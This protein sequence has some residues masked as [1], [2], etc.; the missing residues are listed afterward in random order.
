MEESRAERQQNHQ[1]QQ[2]APSRAALFLLRFFFL[3]PPA[4]GRLLR[5]LGHRLA[6]VLRLGILALLIEPLRIRRRVGRRFARAALF[7]AILH[8]AQHA[9]L[10]GLAAL[11]L[12][13]TVL[14]FLRPR[15]LI[16]RALRGLIFRLRL[17]ISRQRLED[18]RPVIRD[19]VLRLPGLRIV[20]RVLRL[21]FILFQI[22]QLC[23]VFFRLVQQT[24]HIREQVVDLAVELFKVKFA[25]NGSFSA[26]RFP[27]LILF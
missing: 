20:L 14:A 6:P 18:D 8:L 16:F 9:I 4:D 7:P 22:V 27:P 13:Q 19:G 2:N 3:L 23:L 17:L 12:G 21:C 25:H 11:L 15:T 10:L 24:L 5:A 26:R 1:H